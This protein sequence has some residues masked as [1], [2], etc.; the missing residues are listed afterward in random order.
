MVQKYHV[1]MEVH[2]NEN[3]TS[4]KYFNPS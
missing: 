2:E 1:K 3:A 4:E